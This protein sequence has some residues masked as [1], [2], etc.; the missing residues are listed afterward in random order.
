M[1]ITITATKEIAGKKIVLGS[2][3]HQLKVK[4]PK[5]DKKDGRQ[6]GRQEGCCQSQHLVL[7]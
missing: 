2:T 1:T 7:L 5:D 4:K 6:E 3:T